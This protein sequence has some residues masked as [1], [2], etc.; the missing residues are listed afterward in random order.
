MVVLAAVEDFVFGVVVGEF[1]RGE[2]GIACG[3]W[4]TF[5]IPGKSYPSSCLIGNGGLDGGR[6]WLFFA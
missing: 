6:F 4:W 1:L 5:G 3:G 2:G